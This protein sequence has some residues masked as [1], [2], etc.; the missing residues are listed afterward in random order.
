MTFCVVSG[1]TFCVVS[2]KT[3]CVDSDET[4]CV[5]S[6]ETSCF[7]SGETLCVTRD[8]ALL[9]GSVGADVVDVGRVDVMVAGTAVWVCTTVLAS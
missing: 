2:G 7:A 3:F 6:D 9:G 1:D 5:V 8:T 4:F